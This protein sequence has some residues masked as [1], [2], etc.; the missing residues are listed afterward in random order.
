[1]PFTNELKRYID[2]FAEGGYKRTF[3]RDRIAD[4]AKVTPRMVNMWIA[5][6]HL[7]DVVSGQVVAD[8][9]GKKIGRKVTVADVWPVQMS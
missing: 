2:E 6:K 7:P 8:W 3:I 1:M 4:A 9:I 5:G